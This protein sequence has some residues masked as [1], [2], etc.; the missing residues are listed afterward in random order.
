MEPET[1][2][3]GWLRA[4][5]KMVDESSGYL[6]KERSSGEKSIYLRDVQWLSDRM[7]RIETDDG[8]RRLK[9]FY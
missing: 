1:H 4:G 9:S 5:M 3:G 6:C 7:S 2:F 8:I